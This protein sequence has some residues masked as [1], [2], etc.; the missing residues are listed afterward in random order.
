MSHSLATVI[1]SELDRFRFGIAA[2]GSDGDD[3][4]FDGEFVKEGPA[5]AMDGFRNFYKEMGWWTEEEGFLSE[6]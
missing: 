2:L 5:N 4:D 3:D 6:I 1:G